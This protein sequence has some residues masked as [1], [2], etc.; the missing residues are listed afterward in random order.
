VE[1]GGE[2]AG[3][4]FTPEMEKQIPEILKTVF[5]LATEELSKNEKVS[6]LFGDKIFANG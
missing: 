3:E 6:Y 5:R 1:P 4:Q 2:I